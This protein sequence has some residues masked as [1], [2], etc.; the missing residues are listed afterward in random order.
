MAFKLR[1]F[2][3]K[4]LDLIRNGEHRELLFK[5]NEQLFMRNEIGRFKIESNDTFEAMI[6]SVD[7][8]GMLVLEKDGLLSKHHFGELHWEWK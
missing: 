2:L 6:R 5:Y 3:Q 1:I 8:N 7:E 4:Y